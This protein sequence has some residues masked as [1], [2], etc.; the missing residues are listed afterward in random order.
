MRG[1][2]AHNTEVKHVEHGLAGGGAALHGAVLL[3]P[4][5]GQTKAAWLRCNVLAQTVE[6]RVVDLAILVHNGVTEAHGEHAVELTA[7]GRVLL[8]GGLS[9]PCQEGVLVVPPG[10]RAPGEGTV[11]QEKAQLRRCAE[12]PTG[13]WRCG[14]RWTTWC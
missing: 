12:L 6:L 3:L 1:L 7:S 4:V 8:R 9:A 2:S 11:A 10:V 14:R 5:W 13:G